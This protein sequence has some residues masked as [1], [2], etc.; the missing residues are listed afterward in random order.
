MT[1]GGLTS[2]ETTLG[3]FELAG[4]ELVVGAATGVMGGVCTAGITTGDGV[5]GFG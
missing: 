4:F 5:A 3:G 2:A 1:E